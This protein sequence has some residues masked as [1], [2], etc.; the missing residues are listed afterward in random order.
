MRPSSGSMCLCGHCTCI[1][2]QGLL[3]F[4]V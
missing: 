4:V 3:S 1:R 2:N